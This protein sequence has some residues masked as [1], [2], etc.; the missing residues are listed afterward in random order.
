[1][2]WVK[3]SVS[4]TVEHLGCPRSCTKSH[5]ILVQMSELKDAVKQGS[6]LN[7]EPSVVKDQVKYLSRDHAKDE[8]PLISWSWKKESFH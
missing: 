5:K 8:Q 7:T 6:M 1:M 3:V 4:Y 2:G